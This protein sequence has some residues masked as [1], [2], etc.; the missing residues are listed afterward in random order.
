MAESTVLHESVALLRPDDLKFAPGQSPPRRLRCR[1][2]AVDLP[3]TQQG[4]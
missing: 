4:Q 3:R 1:L 2:V